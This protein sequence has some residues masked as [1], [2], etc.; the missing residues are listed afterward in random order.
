MRCPCRHWLCAA[1]AASS[2]AEAAALGK[3]ELL[4]PGLRALLASPAAAGFLLPSLGEEELVKF[5]AEDAK[6]GM[7][8]TD[9]S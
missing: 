7:D 5:D 9:V 4:G 3:V 6:T 1:A 2:D 8:W